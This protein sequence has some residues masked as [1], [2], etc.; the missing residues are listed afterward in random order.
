MVFKVPPV[1]L[2][3]NHVREQKGHPFTFKH[4]GQGSCLLQ[5]QG[6]DQRGLGPRVQPYGHHPQFPLQPSSSN[7]VL[8][9]C[10]SLNLI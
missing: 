2:P 4:Q 10:H 1:P 9:L 8:S 7:Q 5:G 6:L 3:R